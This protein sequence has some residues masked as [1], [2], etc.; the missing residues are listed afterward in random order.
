MKAVSIWNPWAQLSVAGHKK[1]ETRSWPAPRSIIG[2][3]I[4]IA[5]TK[6]IKPEQRAAYG[7]PSFQRFYRAVGFP[8][9]DAMTHGVIIGSVILAACEEMTE[10]LIARTD[11]QELAFGVWTPGRFAWRLSDPVMLREPIPAR[12]AQG[13]WD[14]RGEIV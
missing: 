14:F 8:A 9:L 1:V 7:A 5:A 4:A 11:P 13:V 3:R 6:I 12:G 2:A 10:E